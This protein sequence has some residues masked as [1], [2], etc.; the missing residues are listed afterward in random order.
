MDRVS[1]RIRRTSTHN[2][3]LNIKKKTALL[4]SNLSRESADNVGD[5]C[6]LNVPFFSLIAKPPI[7]GTVACNIKFAMLA[8]RTKSL[9]TLLIQQ[10]GDVPFCEIAQLSVTWIQ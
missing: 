7:L 8:H 6:V 4:D 10:I 1:R 2:N 5:S 9:E 3:Y